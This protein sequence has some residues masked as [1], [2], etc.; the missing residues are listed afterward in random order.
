MNLRVAITE[1]GY[2]NWVTIGFSR[3][4]LLHGVNQLV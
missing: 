4:A 2:V 1:G 3:R